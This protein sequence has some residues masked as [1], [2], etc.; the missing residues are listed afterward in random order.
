M[1]IKKGNIFLQKI[2]IEKLEEAYNTENNAKAKLRLQC[3]ILR[4][5]GKNQSFISEVTGKPITTISDILR[6]FEQRGLD[7]CHAIK[8]TGQPSRLK[9]KQ[10]ISLK[11]ALLQS[12]QKQGLPFTIWTTKLIQYFI[13]KKFGVVYVIRHI[14]YFVF[15]LG[16][17]MQKPR[18]EHIRANKELQAKAKKK[19]DERL[20]NLSK[21]DMRS[22]FWMK[23]SSD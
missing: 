15:S 10:K 1:V 16:L 13:E 11:K 3:A 23:V 8:Q 22:S 19:F 12:P 7:G 2:S 14:H 9:P 17:S 4:K 21:Q 18:P 20:K 6:R 5:K